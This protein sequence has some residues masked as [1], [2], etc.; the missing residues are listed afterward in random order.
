MYH[1]L[2]LRKLIN[3]L[4]NSCIINVVIESTPHALDKGLGLQILSIN[5]YIYFNF[6]SSFVCLFEI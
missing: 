3:Y 1:K 5:I 2:G 4:T 6:L